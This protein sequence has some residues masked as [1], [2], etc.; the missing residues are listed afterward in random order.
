MLLP[1]T[2]G[3]HTR[4]CCRY[5][6][7]HKHFERPVATAAAH[8]FPRQQRWCMYALYASLYKKSVP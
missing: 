5:Q 7:K 3:V 8:G 4:V 2:H 1:I 6:H